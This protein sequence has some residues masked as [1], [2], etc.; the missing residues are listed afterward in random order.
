MSD[1]DHDIIPFPDSGD[2]AGEHEPEDHFRETDPWTSRASAR[3]PF[4]S[5]WGK[6]RWILWNSFYP[7]AVNTPFDPND[8]M[9]LTICRTA[10]EAIVMAGYHHKDDWAR[11]RVGTLAELK[12][13]FC[14]GKTSGRPHTRLSAYSNEW[15]EAF[16]L[17]P[18]GLAYCQG[19]IS[20]KQLSRLAA[21][22]KRR[23]F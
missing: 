23:G 18:R 10:T 11:R 13:I 21:E 17:G 20:W 2:Y 15:Q 14:P 8:P 16:R 9:G 4:G 1:D 7:L 22:E 12:I 3:D 6:A 19:E 5:R